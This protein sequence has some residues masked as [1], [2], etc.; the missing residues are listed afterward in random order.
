MNINNMHM[1]GGKSQRDFGLDLIR[2]FAILFVITAHF[3]LNSKFNTT[4][5]SGI[6]MFVLGAGASLFI[7][8]VP[9]FLI[10][11]GYLNL[12]KRISR[13][14][15]K[16]AIRVLTSYL[17]ISIITILFR[18]YYLHENLTWIQWCLKITDFSAIA[19]G[20]YIE[21]W[22]GLF[23][24]TPFLNILWKAIE[25]RRHKQILIF[26]L[27]LLSA[28]PDFFNR[29]G[30]HLMPG[31]W[32]SIYPVCFFYIGAYIREYQPVIKAKYL[33]GAIVG[34]CLL[35]PTICLFICHDRPM[36]H[37]TADGNGF[38]GIP[39]ATLFFLAVYRI[40]TQSNTLADVIAG[41]SI[42]SLDMYLVSFI[43]DKLYYGILSETILFGPN[44]LLPLFFICTPLVF[45][46]SFV[47]AWIKDLLL[48]MNKK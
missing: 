35:N 45:V 46:S 28:L 24:L 17:L 41:I 8:N 12:N 7:I 44:Y 43:F 37:L 40:R 4:P 38:F 21:M 11:T 32:E 36:M 27:F 34:L 10:L 19:Y 16:G 30:V 33:W 6:G 31:Y 22:I 48:P 20:W 47:F 23:V 1:G 25:T 18:K 26:T 5:Y 2:T 3:F 29:Y 15:Y 9:L 39:I 13:K 42:V 14:Y